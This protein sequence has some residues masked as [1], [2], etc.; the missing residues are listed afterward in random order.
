VVAAVKECAVEADSV[1]SADTDD[2]AE[3]DV[4]LV[5]VA[6][7]DSDDSEDMVT[8]SVDTGEFVLNESAEKDISADDVTIALFVKTLTVAGIDTE[9]ENEGFEAVAAFVTEEE[10]DTEGLADEVKES[11]EGVGAADIDDAIVFE[12]V[13]DPIS[14]VEESID[15]ELTEF[16]FM[17]VAIDE[18]EVKLDTDGNAVPEVETVFN[19]DVVGILVPLVVAEIVEVIEGIDEEE[20]LIVTVSKTVNV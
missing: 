6:T 13:C 1:N 9:D 18:T 20:T 7:S 5:A 19:P 3:K 11:T 10:D 15:V 4:A 17:A 14:T 2:N 12:D 8:D 16:V